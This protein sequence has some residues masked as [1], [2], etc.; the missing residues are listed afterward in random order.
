MLA[1]KTVM[2][3][4]L[5]G[6]VSGVVGF[7][8]GE[9]R[10]AESSLEKPSE[11]YKALLLLELRGLSPPPTLDAAEQI[12]ESSIPQRAF[13]GPCRQRVSAHIIPR[14]VLKSCLVKMFL[15]IAR[16]RPEYSTSAQGDTFAI[17]NP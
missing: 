2:H 6:S 11:T 13:L 3:C 15:G 8:V 12:V 4:T 17:S 9:P 16:G 5:V 7:I 1:Q 10:C 14:S